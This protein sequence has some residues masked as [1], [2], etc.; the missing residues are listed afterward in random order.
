VSPTHSA[1]LRDF[2]AELKAAIPDLKPIVML[3]VDSFDWST[4]ESYTVLVRAEG[5]HAVYVHWPLD[6]RPDADAI[7]RRAE[8]AEPLEASR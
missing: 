4:P 5:R 8:S 3:T 6:G 1:A 2:E 7:R